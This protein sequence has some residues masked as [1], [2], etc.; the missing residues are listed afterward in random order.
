MISAGRNSFYLALVIALVATGT[1]ILPLMFSTAPFLFAAVV[2]LCLAFWQWDPIL[3]IAVFLLPFA[4][5]VQTDFPIHD[6]VSLLR[7][8]IF[9]GVFLRRLLDRGNLGK[10]LF[11]TTLDKLAILY[12]A[13]ATVSVLINPGAGPGMR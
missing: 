7:I 9:A 4:P 2:V 5:I 3:Y 10:W 1:I 11:G 12:L 8:L 13:I 6:L